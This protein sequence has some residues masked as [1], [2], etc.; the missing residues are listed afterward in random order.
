MS[1]AVVGTQELIR[2][3]Q[4]VNQKAL[5]VVTEPELQNLLVRRILG[6]FDQGVDPEGSPWPGLMASTIKRKQRSGHGNAGS[7]LKESGRLRNSIGVVAGSNQGLLAS[8]TGLGF[9]IG[10]N[11]PVAAKYGRLHNSGIGG[12]EKRQFLGIGSLDVR[13]VRDYINRRL[14]SIAEA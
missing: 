9:R 11:D 2:K 13:S 7:I 6:R 5:G 12:Q 14:K 3:L 4:R 10:V 8:S 1:E